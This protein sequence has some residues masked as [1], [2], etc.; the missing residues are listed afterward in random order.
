MAHGVG[1]HGP[2]C[3]CVVREEYRRAQEGFAEARRALARR[4]GVPAVVAPSELA[5][6]QWIDDELRGKSRELATRRRAHG[7]AAL[8]LLGTRTLALLWTA[9]V[10][11][12]VVQ[13]LTAIGAGWTIT[14]TAALVAAVVTAAGL[15]AVAYATREGAGLYAPARGLDGRL[16]TSKAVAALWAVTLT[17][18]FVFFA[19]RLAAASD[20]DDRS[21]LLDSLGSVSADQLALV[22]APLFAA[23]LVRRVV[24]DKVNRRVLQKPHS[25]RARLFDLV[26]DDAGRSSLVD[27]QY[28]LVNLVATGFVVVGLARDP[29][30]LPD[31]P[32]TLVALAMV[33]VVVYLVAKLV[34]NNRPVILS[35][36]RVHVPGNLDTA[37]RQGDD[38]EIRGTNLVGAGAKDPDQLAR[39]VVMFGAVHVYAPLVPTDSGFANPCDAVIVVPIPVDVEPGR[40]ELCVVSAAGIESNRYEIEIAD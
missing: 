34:E 14:R 4:E 40:V 32:A 22:A 36:V 18:T 24:G 30:A 27:A 6:R 9:V 7:R 5:T 12:L 16:S 21:D 11:L 19:V 17:Y 33:S 15:S 35:V 31:I 29:E 3:H 8:R 25:D 39:V 13:S 10:V 37:V 38:I 1:V 2:D 20:G 28:V 26:T 23:V